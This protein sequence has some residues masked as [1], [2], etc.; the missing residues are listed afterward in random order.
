MDGKAGRGGARRLRGTISNEDCLEGVRRLDENSVQLAIADPPYNIGKAEWDEWDSVGEYLDWCLRWISACCRALRRDG[1][2]YI[3]HNDMR[4][5]ARLMLRIE[6][7]TPLRYRRMIV[8]NKRFRVASSDGRRSSNFGYLTGYLER[9]GKRNYER[10]AEY[11]LYYTFDNGGRIRRAREERGLS[12]KDL[13]RECPSR[14]GGITGWVSN[15]EL[16]KSYPNGEQLETLEERLGLSEGDLI[17]KFRNRGTHHSV[18]DYEIAERVGHET[19]KPRPLIRNILLHSSDP[20]DLV[21]VPFSGLGNVELTCLELGRDFV[22]FETDPEYAE[23]AR[24][25]LRRRQRS[26]TEFISPKGDERTLDGLEAG[27]GD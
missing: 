19:P 5:V 23:R 15:V 4:Q 18:W 25:R 12:Q 10:M 3:F 13:A 24:R 9:G 21:L 11:L 16:G 14:T 6:E 8:W 1:S 26:V 7:G 17:P 27:E 20:G 2:L 22:G